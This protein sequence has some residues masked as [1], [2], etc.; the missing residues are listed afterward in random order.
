MGALDRFGLS[1]EPQYGIPSYLE[2]RPLVARHFD[3]VADFD[4]VEPVGV[5][6]VGSKAR[7]IGSAFR[8]DAAHGPA[9]HAAGEEYL[10]HSSAATAAAIAP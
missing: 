7:E 1:H 3:W 2:M 9:E 5:E 4:H 8:C 6:C 10:A